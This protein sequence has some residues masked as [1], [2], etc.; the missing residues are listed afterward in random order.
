MVS[1]I[2][3]AQGSGDRKSDHSVQPEPSDYQQA[4]QQANISDT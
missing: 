4:K 2:V 3:A 1:G